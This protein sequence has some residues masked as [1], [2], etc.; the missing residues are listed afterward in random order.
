MSPPTVTHIHSTYAATSF[1][2]SQ[3]EI[4]FI[5]DS[6]KHGVFG[7]HA[8]SYGTISVVNKE[9]CSLTSVHDSE[10]FRAAPRG[11]NGIVKCKFNTYVSIAIND[12]GKL[13]VW[14]YWKKSW[15]KGL[16]FDIPVADFFIDENNLRIFSKD[17]D[18][19]KVT[20]RNADADIENAVNTT[21]LAK[22]LST[23]EIPVEIVNDGYHCAW[24]KYAD[25]VSIFVKS[26]E[27]KEEKFKSFK[28]DNPMWVE[29]FYDKVFFRD[30]CGVLRSVDYGYMDYRRDVDEFFEDCL[31]SAKFCTNHYAIRED[32]SPVCLGILYR[33]STNVL[34][35]LSFSGETKILSDQFITY[36]DGKPMPMGSYAR[37]K[38]GTTLP[39]DIVLAAFPEFN[40]DTEYVLELVKRYPNN[41]NYASERIRKDID[42]NKQIAPISESHYLNIDGGLRRNKEIRT[43]GKLYS[44][45]G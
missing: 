45:G 36:L 39:R 18:V 16:P 1:V 43:F 12:A 14:G 6:G 40:D 26:V 22:L 9:G 34:D 28:V 37:T 42:F 3:G 41:L 24:V 44:L 31:K 25:H 17:G 4:R 21:I 7:H 10:V 30:N 2:T 15:L 13:Y 19:Y 29:S 32:N 27:N 20:F 5:G 35:I 33:H 23:K 8:K 11:M 38:D